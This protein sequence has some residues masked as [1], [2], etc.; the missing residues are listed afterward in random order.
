MNKNTSL[1]GLA[2][3]SYN[4]NSWMEKLQAFQKDEEL[5]DKIYQILSNKGREYELGAGNAHSAFNINTNHS[6]PNNKGLR[7]AIVAHM[8]NKVISYEIN[9]LK[10]EISRIDEASDEIISKSYE[11]QSKNKIHPLDFAGIVAL[12]TKDH[13]GKEITKYAILTQDLTEG[14]TLKVNA[15]TADETAI[16]TTNEGEFVK[17][18]FM[19]PAKSAKDL[20]RANKYL[21]YDSMLHIYR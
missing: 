4:Y 18:V 21:D 16:V 1:E 13:K 15:G 6:S 8:N 10:R 12:H 19:D 14:R 9:D 2:N 7:T 3:K 20:T 5:G 11:T 17:E